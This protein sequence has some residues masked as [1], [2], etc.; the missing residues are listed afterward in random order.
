MGAFIAALVVAVGI[1][2]GAAAG[3]EHYQ[4]YA[5]EA[6]VG[7]GAKPDKHESTAEKPKN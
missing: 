4:K 5:D 1:A 6:F 3:L 7:S 2:F